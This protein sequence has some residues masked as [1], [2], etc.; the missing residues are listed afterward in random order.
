MPVGRQC[1]GSRRHQVDRFEQPAGQRFQERLQS[2]GP[3]AGEFEVAT[4]GVAAAAPFVPASGGSLRRQLGRPWPVRRDLL[5]RLLPFVRDQGELPAE[6]DGE[7]V[8]LGAAAVVF[9][10][11]P[12]FP[13]AVVPGRQVGTSLVNLC[14][15]VIDRSRVVG[16]LPVLSPPTH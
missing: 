13:A 15:F 11:P 7:I 2:V 4:I 1:R 14:D 10:L 16:R 3:G 6:G 9:E 8:Q 5:H 12:R